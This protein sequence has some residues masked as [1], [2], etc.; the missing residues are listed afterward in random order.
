M[1]SFVRTGKVAAILLGWA[2]VILPG[3]AQSVLFVEHRGKMQPVIAARDSLPV[4]MEDGK[5]ISVRT[6]KFAMAKVEEFS[7]AF[8]AV[9][10]VRVRDS[11]LQLSGGGD[12]NHTFE[13]NAQFESAYV[14][15]DVFVVLEFEFDSGDKSL[16]LNQVG[17]LAP[18]NSR[19]INLA[20][21]ISHALGEGKYYLHIFSG[22]MEVFHSQQP[23][24]F[25]D[26][27]LDQ[28]IAKRIAGSPDRNPQP[29]IGPPPEYPRKFTK[30]RIK[31]S[32][33]LHFT[34]RANG[35]VDNPTIVT[36]SDPAFGEAALDSIRMWRFLPRIKAGRPIETSVDL[37]MEF[38]PPEKS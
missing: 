26:A 33:R 38:E 19:F 23:F 1:V 31:G 9:Q 8:V 34:I 25:R 18:H 4:I 14:L 20:A 30:S 7:P 13:F 22:G 24:F 35:A 27:M 16:F 11:Y 12:I 15:K 3:F 37:P 29:F 17:D 10:D 5:R 32:V 28:M 6:D 36:A 21:P 2:A